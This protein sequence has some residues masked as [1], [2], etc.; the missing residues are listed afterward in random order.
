M[1]EQSAFSKCV[2]MQYR[3]RATLRARGGNEF[4]EPGLSSQKRAAC[5]SR[6]GV[7]CVFLPGKNAGAASPACIHGYDSGGG[8]K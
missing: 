3:Q 2:K 5:T 7:D 4:C 8:A 1:H 6:L